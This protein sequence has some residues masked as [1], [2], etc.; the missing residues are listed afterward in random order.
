MNIF[1]FCSPETLPRRGCVAE[2]HYA[3]QSGGKGD[4]A[5]GISVRPCDF[6]ETDAFERRKAEGRNK[7]LNHQQKEKILGDGSS[8]I[9]DIDEQ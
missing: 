5:H 7:I 9:I 6:Q 3:R 8:N 1:R 4:E 2:I